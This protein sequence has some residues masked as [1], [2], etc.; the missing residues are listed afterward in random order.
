MWKFKLPKGR[1]RWLFLLTIGVILFILAFP[2]GKQEGKPDSGAKKGRETTGANT[3]MVQ[4]QVLETDPV[5]MQAPAFPAAAAPAASYEEQLEQRVKE[6]LKDVDGVGQVEVMIVLKSSAEKVIHVDGSSSVSVTEEE[7]SGGGTRRIQSQEENSST[8]L[9]SDE[10]GSSG[11]HPVIEK[12]LYPEISG[13]VITAAG[14]G[15]PTV[16][17]EISSAMEAL[18]GLPAHKIKVLKRAE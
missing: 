11:T 2:V 13:I 4:E 18:F 6:I 15:N 7:D 1:D 17:A 16:R 14:G 12:E 8:V 10:G 5:G 9:V 3:E